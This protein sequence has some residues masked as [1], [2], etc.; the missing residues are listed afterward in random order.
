MLSAIVILP[1]PY[2]AKWVLCGCAYVFM[3]MLSFP[4]RSIKALLTTAEQFVWMAVLYGGVSWILWRGM[5]SGVP[6]DWKVVTFL[7]LSTALF[8]FFWARGCMKKEQEKG[9]WKVTLIKDQKKIQVLGMVDSG[10]SLFEPISGKPVCVLDPQIADFLWENTDPFRVIP[11]HCIDTENGI[12]KG[13]LLSELRMETGGPEIVRSDV[14]V[15]VSPRKMT[16][17][18]GKAAFLIHPTLLEEQGERA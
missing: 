14:Y 4:V 3:V 8:C 7:L 13:Y 9:T 10:N 1:V 18:E 6:K 11:Y 2:W 15:A 5:L 17:G 16:K 12:L